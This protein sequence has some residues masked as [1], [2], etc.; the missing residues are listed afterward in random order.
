MGLVHLDLDTLAWLPT[1]PPERMPIEQ[2]KLGIE[3]FTHRNQQWVIE[4]CYSDL[5]EPLLGDV[6]EIIFMNLDVEQCTANAKN[7]PWEPHK[8]ESKEAQDANLDMLINWI[9]D[10]KVRSDTFSYQSHQAL[11]SSFNGKK[12]MYTGNRKFI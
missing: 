6:S 4:G 2:S 7:R 12:T 1:S 10:Y 3:K 9:N 11:Y 5:L 8:Y